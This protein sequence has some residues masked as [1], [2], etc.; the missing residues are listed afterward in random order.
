MRSHFK[1]AVLIADPDDNLDEPQATDPVDSH[2]LRAL[3]EVL[4]YPHCPRCHAPLVA[5][6][7]RLGPS[8]LCLCTQRAS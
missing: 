3:A 2:Q 1:P 5:L 4:A 6:Q 7:T 8:F